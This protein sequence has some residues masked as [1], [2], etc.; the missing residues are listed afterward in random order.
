MT[1]DIQE[2][3][4]RYMRLSACMENELPVS[5]AHRLNGNNADINAD[6]TEFC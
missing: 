5:H 6:A 4:L 2:E 3:R 1:D